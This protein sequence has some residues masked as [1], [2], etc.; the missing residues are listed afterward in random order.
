MHIHEAS[1]RRDHTLLPNANC[2]AVT[3]LQTPLMLGCLR[4]HVN[5]IALVENKRTLYP[6]LPA[7]RANGI[8]SWVAR[9]MNTQ[10]SYKP[11]ALRNLLNDTLT[12]MDNKSSFLSSPIPRALYRATQK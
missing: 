4:L 8:R 7:H 11:L 6:F 9:S 12:S 10:K 3:V 2:E 5:A 1:I